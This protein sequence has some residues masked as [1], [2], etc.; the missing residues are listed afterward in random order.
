MMTTSSQKTASRRCRP[1]SRRWIVS[2][3]TI[4]LASFCCLVAG[5]EQITPEELQVMTDEELEHIC[6]VRGFELVKDD[7]DEATGE[8]YTLS[9]DDFV[10]A[11][12]RCLAIEEEM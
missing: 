12:Q 6:L 9:H 11:A 10:E 8:I 2:F 3:L 1:L 5:Q 4:V 7:V